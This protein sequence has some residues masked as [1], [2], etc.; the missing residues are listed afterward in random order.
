VQPVRRGVEKLSPPETGAARGK[1]RN[2]ERAGRLAFFS[3]L[4]GLVVSR[5]IEE[6]PG[7]RPNGNRAAGPS[8]RRG[9]RATGRPGAARRGRAGGG[10]PGNRPNA[11]RAAAGRGGPR[12]AGQPAERALRDPG[13]GPSI[14]YMEG[15]CHI[16]PG[17]R[18]IATTNTPRDPAGGQPAAV[19]LGPASCG[20]AGASQLRSGR[21]PSIPNGSLPG[22]RR[23]PREGPLAAGLSLARRQA[24]APGP[25]AQ[26]PPRG[27]AAG[28]Q[29]AGTAP[30]TSSPPCQTAATSGT[31]GRYA[32]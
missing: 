14:P 4:L 18:R 25:G 20:P 8:G 2:A 10:K 7:N 12:D 16:V 30:A 5:A 28:R 17:Q 22:W 3:G 15:P 24:S 29:V 21:G 23:G 9:S 26:A 11:N 27:P 1:P 32:R 6:R 19:R 13:Q 31:P